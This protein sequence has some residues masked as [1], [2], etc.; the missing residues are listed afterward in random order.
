MARALDLGLSLM[1]CLWRARDTGIL[2]IISETKEK[3]ICKK[4]KVK[5]GNT[6]HRHGRFK[7]VQ[8]LYF[9]VFLDVSKSP[10][11]KIYDSRGTLNVHLSVCLSMYLLIHTHTHRLFHC[12]NYSRNPT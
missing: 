6:T 11:L 9:H 7:V 2:L 10:N 3:M 4:A 12:D 1:G 8:T 5:A